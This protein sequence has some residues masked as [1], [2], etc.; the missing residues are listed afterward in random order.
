MI[1]PSQLSKTYVQE[2]REVM[3]YEGFGGFENILVIGGRDLEV[4][5]FSS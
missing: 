3:E 4:W 1:L 5:S 2:L